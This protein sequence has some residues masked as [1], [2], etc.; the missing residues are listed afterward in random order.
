MAKC[1]NGEG[2]IPSFLLPYGI[3]LLLGCKVT[4]FIL[5]CG[6]KYGKTLITIED[7]FIITF[8]IQS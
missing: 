8:S 6:N 5:N 7:C 2:E 1:T 4:N 3:L